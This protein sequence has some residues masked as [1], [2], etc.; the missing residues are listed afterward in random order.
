MIRCLPRVLVAAVCHNLHAVTWSTQVLDSRGAEGMVSEEEWRQVALLSNRAAESE[1]S[2]GGVAAKDLVPPLAV[3]GGGKAKASAAATACYGFQTR[4]QF[5]GSDTECVLS[6][7]ARRSTACTAC[8][9][10]VPPEPTMRMPCAGMGI[11]S[12]PC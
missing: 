4:A 1:E 11:I 12:S 6:R 2:A 7:L 8:H 3:A 5:S 9:Q 10:I